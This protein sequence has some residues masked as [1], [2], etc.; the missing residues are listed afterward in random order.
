MLTNPCVVVFIRFDG[1][2]VLE[3]AGDVVE[4]GEEHD[5]HDGPPRLLGCAPAW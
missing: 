4:D 1:S 3:H 2:L 5:D